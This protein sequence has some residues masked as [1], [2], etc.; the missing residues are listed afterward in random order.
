MPNQMFRN[1]ETYEKVKLQ[2]LLDTE[3]ICLGFLCKN[4]FVVSEFFQVKIA[5][6]VTKSRE[7]INSRQ[8][9]S[10]LSYYSCMVI[11]QIGRG[12]RG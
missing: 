7:T 8:Y 9:F 10:I 4:V 5:A 1:L 12:K 11:T 2:T 3:N 6:K